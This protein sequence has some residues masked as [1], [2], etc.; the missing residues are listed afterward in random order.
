MIDLA[1]IRQR[2]ERARYEVTA[3]ASGQAWRPTKDPFCG[4]SSSILDAALGDVDRLI[5][6]LE[7]RP[8]TTLQVASTLELLNIFGILKITKARHDG[9][10]IVLTSAIDNPTSN[11][12]A[13]VV[14][15]IE[16][17][18]PDHPA[19]VR[20]GNCAKTVYEPEPKVLGVI[21]ASRF[22]N[23]CTMC[24]KECVVK[25]RL[26]RNEAF[27]FFDYLGGLRNP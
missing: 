14:A 21:D 3:L 1:P 4:G 7:A 25:D 26:H 12:I 27:R 6:E 22:V 23:P 9:K 24:K 10:T 17:S 5:K 18:F 15:A 13:T 20:W 8:A 11:Q 2:L 16:A 19:I